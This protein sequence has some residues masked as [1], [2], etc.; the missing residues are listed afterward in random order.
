MAYHQL[1][2]KEQERL[3]AL[4]DFQEQR[5]QH[6]N[7]EIVTLHLLSPPNKQTSSRTKRKKKSPK[8]KFIP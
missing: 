5:G 4:S 1:S 3:K 6:A 7:S 2:A 8:K